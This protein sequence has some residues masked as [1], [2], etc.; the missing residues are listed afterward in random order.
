[1]RT[2]NFTLIIITLITLI[3]SLVSCGS[4]EHKAKSI[5]KKIDKI[6]TSKY[7]Y[8]NRDK[9]NE[10]IL[11]IPEECTETLFLCNQKVLK[12]DINHYNLNLDYDISKILDMINKDFDNW[13][14]YLDDD[15]IL[16][17]F[18]KCK[19]YPSTKAYIELNNYTKEDYD[20]GINHMNYNN[21]NWNSALSK[22]IIHKAKQGDIVM[23][24]KLTE[25]FAPNYTYV[26]RKPTGKSDFWSGDKK[27]DVKFKAIDSDIT[28]ITRKKINA[29]RMLETIEQE[30]NETKFARGSSLLKNTT[31]LNKLVTLLQQEQTFSVKFIGHT[32]TD[33]TIETNQQLSL[34]RAKAAAKY[35]ESKGI[36]L[37]RIYYEGK[38]SSE[39]KN[40]IDPT[41]E[42]NCR[43]EIVLL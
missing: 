8:K 31:A 6:V 30:F 42:E 3:L 24:N 27:Y 28:K 20:S 18:H 17:V 7:T 40:N 25:L 29:Y 36:S 15:F 34:D 1:M 38:G 39:L 33:G 4:P 21:N 14:K 26:S 10:L 32:S 2:K 41:S 5:S 13:C 16:S 22:Y 23:A 11:Q 9:L 37:S 43:I 35:V 12:Y 19:S